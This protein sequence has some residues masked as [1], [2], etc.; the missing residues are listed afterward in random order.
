[1]RT[2]TTAEQLAVLEQTVLRLEAALRVG[3][4]ALA[5]AQRL[6]SI[7]AETAAELAQLG[8]VLTAERH[9][10]RLVVREINTE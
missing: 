5:I 4:D 8:R 10:A 7:D 2:L 9:R 3:R 6:S 1:M